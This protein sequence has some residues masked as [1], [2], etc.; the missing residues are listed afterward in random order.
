MYRIGRQIIF[1]KLRYLAIKTF[2]I[3]LLYIVFTMLKNIKM[4]VNVDIFENIFSKTLLKNPAIFRP[5]E[6]QLD[7]RNILVVKRSVFTFGLGL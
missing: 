3:Y 6:E 1:T 2:C 7:I 4:I 5:E